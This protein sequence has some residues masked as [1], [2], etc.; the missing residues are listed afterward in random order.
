MKSLTQLIAIPKS[1]FS[2]L[3]YCYHYLAP[4]SQTA[5]YAVWQEQDETSFNADNKKGER[6]LE[7]VIDFYTLKE[8]DAKLDEIENALVA[9]GA[10]WQ[11][12]SVMYESETNLIHFSWDWSVS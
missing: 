5:P 10:A 8:S 2:K 7:G 9:M 11:L 12:T 4:A 3:S 6:S 1:E